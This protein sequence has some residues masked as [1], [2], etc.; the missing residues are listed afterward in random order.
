M[1]SSVGNERSLGE[2]QIIKMIQQRHSFGT[3]S[4]EIVTRKIISP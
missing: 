3:E 1:W 4:N 2:I